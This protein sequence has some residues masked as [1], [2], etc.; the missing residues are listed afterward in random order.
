M[1]RISIIPFQSRWSCY[2]LI[3]PCLLT[4]AWSAEV[5]MTASDTANGSVTSFNGNLG[6]WDNGAAPTAGNNYTNAAFLLRSPNAGTSHPFA[7]DSLT[8]TRTAS[9]IGR[10]LLK[11]PDG[12]MVTVSQLVLMGGL[13]DMGVGTDTYTTRLAGGLSIPAG[14]KNY[15]SVAGSETA[16][17]GG[18]TLDI[19][20]TVSGSGN[21]QIGGIGGS[22]QLEGLTV[23]TAAASHSGG[24]VKLSS[25]NSFSGRMILSGSPVN[26]TRGGLQIA[27]LNALAQATL[28][29]ATL[30]SGTVPPVSF[31]ASANTGPFLIATVEGSAFQPLKD[32]SDSAIT[33]GI[34]G[35]NADSTFAGAFTGSG[36]LL[37][38]GSGTLS[39]TG[40]NAYT[41][42]TTVSAGV[43]SLTHPTLAD[44]SALIIAAGATLELDHQE[45]DVVA[46]LILDG[47]SKSEGTYDASNSDGF[48]TGTGSIRVG[49]APPADSKYRAASVWQPYDGSSRPAS[50]VGSYF[51]VPFMPVSESASTGSLKIAGDGQATPIHYSSSDATVVGIAASA[52][53]D[54]VNRVTGIVPELSTNAPSADEVILIGTIGSSPLIDSLVSGGKIDVSAIQGKW[55]AYQAAVVE[56]PLPGV[57]RALVIAGSDRR[58]TAFGVFALSESMGV[59][60][61]YWWGDVPVP[62][63]S[64]V[65]IAG[66]HTQSSPG[67]K[68]RGIFLNDEDWGLQPWAAKTFETEV[69]NIGPKTYA[70]IFELLLRLHANVIWPAMHEFPVETTP[71]YLVPQNK[72]VAD[73]Y[74]IVISTSHHEPM[75]RNSHEYDEAVLGAYNYW[76]NRTSIYNFWEQRVAETADY[77]NIYTIGLRGRTDAGMLAPAGTTDAQKAEKIQNEIIPDQRQMISDHVNADASEIPQIFIPYKETLVQYQAGLQL[78]DDVTILWPDDNHGYIRQLSNTAERARSGGSGVYYHLSYW[79]VPRSYLWLCTT[80]PGMTC[81]EMMKAW[82]FQA[83]KMWLVNVGDLKPHEIGTEFFLR[84]ARDPEAF[85]NFDQTAYFTQWAQRNFGSGHAAS[86]AAALNEYFRLNI[87]KRPEHLDRSSGG[88]SLIAEGDEA[89]QRL[90]QFDA[91]TAAAEAIYSQLPAEQK[92]AFYEMILYPARGSR[93]VNRRILLAERSRLWAT[94]KRATTA[95]LSA[96]AQAAHSSLLAETQFYNQGNAGGKWNYMLSPMATSSLPAWAQETQNAFIMPTVGSYT[97]PSTASLGVVIEGASTPLAEGVSAELPTFNRPANRSYFIDIFNQ[98]MASMSWTAQAN[99]PW[100]TLSQTSG[101]SDARIKVGIDWAKVTRGHAIPG[102]VVITGAGSERTINLHAFYPHDLDLTTLPSKVEDNGVV[103]IEAEDFSSRVDRAD[104]T[105]WRRV[106]K[107]TASEDGVT[108]LPVTQSSLDPSNLPADTP[109]LTYQFYSFHTGATKIRTECLPT[110]RI[111]SEHPGL[112]FAISLNSDTPKIVD[113]HANEYSTAW[114][115]NTLRAASYGVSSHEI[116][117]KGLQTVKIWM[118]DPGVVLDRVVIETKPGLYEA[119]G[120]NVQSSTKPTVIYTDTPASGGAG[121]HFQSTAVNDQMV[122]EVPGLPAGDY[123]FSFRVKKWTSRGIVQMAVAESAA[124]PWTNVGDPLDLYNATELYTDLGPFPVTF[125]TSEPQYV[126]FTVTGKNASSSNYWVLLDSLTFDPATSATGEPIKDWRFAY[127]GT[128]SAVDDADDLAD[129]DQDGV[130]NLVEYATGSTPTAPNPSPVSATFEDGHLA[131]T[132]NRVLNATDITY[133]VV[134]GSDIPPTTSVWSSET[135]PYPGGAALSAPTTVVD[136]EPVGEFDKRFLVLKVTRP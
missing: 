83:D 84:M 115:A 73:D 104:G 110:H 87:T 2:G 15:I 135:V 96:E 74:A 34:G 125:S 72:A 11:G 19:T 116:A 44:G 22:A 62:H 51:A 105:G 88:F 23:P 21:V 85:R 95:A 57:G 38:L 92:P 103:I 80:P 82:D 49:V 53:R 10:L 77:E 118:V 117:A 131:L 66:S 91:M 106:D 127:F 101:T 18:E 70:T 86:I 42:N 1:S 6:R 17:T 75:L 90:D 102:K 130:S 9:S 3:L 133:R 47:V 119:E 24:T 59:S 40:T 78:P 26:T 64:A 27:H 36:N 107:A 114:N 121:R 31:L 63:K 4:S 60:P 5:K 71:F 81:S 97:A 61:W 14:A 35:T 30:N 8:L 56:N 54:D 129:P 112:R 29:I 68:Y 69:G 39:L 123:L 136:P 65:H 45:A 67:V 52:L 37:K 79:G 89:Q 46:E 126:R 13:L 7:G 108:I 25:A 50:P 111:T 33:L 28:E 100:I 134:A 113:V 76:T 124:G 20:A 55:E 128:T 12:D 132:F 48:I 16:G 41:G 122:L 109:S 32:T 94:Q 93:W 98:G 99:A 43:L 120:L 58:G